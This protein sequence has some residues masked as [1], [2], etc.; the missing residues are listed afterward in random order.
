MSKH[1]IQWHKECLENMRASAHRARDAAQRALNDA[2]RTEREC[3]ALDAMII[4]AELR[5]L[6]GFDE[7]KF[8]KKRKQP[9][10]QGDR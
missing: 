3:M 10:P 1:S 4:E 9:R 2:E 6:D 7:A 5:G 8:C